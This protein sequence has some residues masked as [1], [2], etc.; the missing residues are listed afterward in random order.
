[1]AT[2]ARIAIELKD[3]SFISSYQ[4]WDGYPGGLG[5]TLIDHWTDYAKTKE[6]IEL[7]DASSWRYM[8]GQQI[9]FDDRSNPLH[10][11]QNCYYG[12][13]RGEK[14][15]GYHKHMNGVVLLDEAFNSGEE[16]LYILKDVSKKVDEEKYEW[17]FVAES[18]PRF[19]IM[20]IKPLFEVAVQDHIDML[21]RTLEMKKQGQFIG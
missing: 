12:R 5:Y 1:M 7:G 8:V 19:D 3:G 6:A 13:D 11:V 17:F 14:D 15:V 18:D 10:D 21:K 2:R 16:Y 9:D 20:D 4:H